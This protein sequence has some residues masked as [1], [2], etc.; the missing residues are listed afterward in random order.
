[1]SVGDAI[2][3]A[4][5]RV[6]VPLGYQLDERSAQSATFESP[7]AAVV[8][9]YVQ[10]DGELAV[11]VEPKDGGEPI[12]LLLYLR[13]V[14]SDAATQLGDAVAETEEEAARQAE[15]FASGLKD[16]E[17]LLR[18]EETAVQQARKLRWWSANPPADLT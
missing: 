8:A 16:A 5:S 14:G 12:Q 1:M 17:P 13:A 4:F 9:R 11:Y 10:R 6:L 3:A 2:E 15:L 18:A 7:L